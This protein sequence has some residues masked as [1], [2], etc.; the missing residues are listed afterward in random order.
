MYG[1]GT[2]NVVAEC[3]GKLTLI[4]PD[5]F[6][7]KLHAFLSSMSTLIRATII[8]AIKFTITDQPL[9]I[10]P[11]LKEHFGKFLS[12]LEVSADWPRAF[13]L[14]RSFYAHATKLSQS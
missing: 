11:L 2:R 1:L 9:P 10:D 14:L 3:L 7:E 4:H 8:T 6:L 13:L 12:L 5:R